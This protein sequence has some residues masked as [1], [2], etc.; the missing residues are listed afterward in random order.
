MRPED[1]TTSDA[2][3]DELRRP[4]TLGDVA[5]AIGLSSATVSLVLNQ[6]PAADAIPAATQQRVFEAARRLNYRPNLLARSLRRRKSF[7]VGILV[8][9]LGGYSSGLMNGI[10]DYL[11]EKRWAYFLAAHRSEQKLLQHYLELF[12]DHQVAGFLLIGALVG[13]P[14]PL[15]TVVI[16]GLPEPPSVTH[17]VVDHDAAALDALTHLRDLGHRRIAFFRGAEG[18]IDA[19]DRWR[20]IREVAPAL[21]IGIDESLVLQLSRGDSDEPLSLED[22]YIAGYESGRELLT[23]GTDFTALFAF[24]DVSAI[25]AVRAFL[26]AGLGVPQDVSVVGFDDIESAAFHNPSLTTVRQPLHEMG[27]LAAQRLLELLG[28]EPEEPSVVAVRPQLVVRDST[29]PASR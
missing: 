2:S 20:A 10:D 6:S 12:Q 26:D 18:N 8:S 1:P 5:A 21:G 11:L 28:E 22:G 27:E 29:A 7:T 23:R 24:N 25:G 19:A 16:S 4:A 13:E 3:A 14:P 9:D 17:V 15:P